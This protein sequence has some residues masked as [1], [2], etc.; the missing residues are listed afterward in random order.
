M[1]VFESDEHDAGDVARVN[2]GLFQI[3][4]LALNGVGDGV[5]DFLLGGSALEGAVEAVVELG[6]GET[7][8]LLIVL[9]D[10]LEEGQIWCFIGGE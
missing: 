8:W 6:P 7:L 1:E 2:L 5:Y 10:D 9:L 3:Q 4:Y